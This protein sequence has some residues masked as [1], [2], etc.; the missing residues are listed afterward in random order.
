MDQ[1]KA[2]PG[3]SGRRVS[4][5][6]TSATLAT[7]EGDT[8]AEFLVGDKEIDLKVHSEESARA[9]AELVEGS[10]GA[11]RTARADTRLALE[12]GSVSQALAELRDAQS[13]SSHQLAKDE[14][15]AVICHRL[16]ASSGCAT[17]VRT[18]RRISINCG[19]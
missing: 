5:I 8:F 13:Y 1:A 12:M 15:L 9:I 19:A 18:L 3:S 7:S 4:T 16:E 11:A 2:W 14:R 17:V 10:S 6:D